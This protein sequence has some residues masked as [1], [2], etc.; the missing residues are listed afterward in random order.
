MATVHHRGDILRDREIRRE[1]RS[2]LE[3]RFGGDPDV[4]ILDEFGLPCARI[5]LAVVNCHL[6]GYEIKSSADNLH[7]LEFQVPA[8]SAVFDRVT[9][10]AGEC[11]VE[12]LL[13]RVPLWWDV[14]SPVCRGG[15]IQLRRVRLGASNPE[16]KRA[17]IARL[18]WRDEALAALR[19]RGLHKG[20]TRAS[21]AQVIAKLSSSLTLH[22]I[23]EAARCAIRQRGPRPARPAPSDGL[24]TTAPTAQDRRQNFEWLLSLQ[25]QHH[26]H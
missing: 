12:E 6:L 16:R 9:V 21:K 4:V 22:E 18:L 3:R 15:K 17:E 2:R 20:L 14:F 10:L 26:Q 23:A 11:H 1:L 19:G 8:Y 24:Y 7:R 5:D 25:S 13:A